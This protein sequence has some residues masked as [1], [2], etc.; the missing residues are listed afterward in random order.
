MVLTGSVLL[1]AGRLNEVSESNTEAVGLAVRQ[2][3]GN[4]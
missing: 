3:K 1:L 4:G 2:E